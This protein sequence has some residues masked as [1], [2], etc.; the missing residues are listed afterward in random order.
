MS[1]NEK[2][3]RAQ[4]T[5]WLLRIVKDHGSRITSDCGRADAL[6]AK[7]NVLLEWEKEHSEDNGLGFHSS[8]LATATEA[9][10]NAHKH[11]LEWNQLDEFVLDVFSE[12]IAEEKE[13]P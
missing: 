10:S 7:A 6:V 4:L 12:M 3:T 13:Q 1:D 5:R 11:M 2:L 8:M 9:A